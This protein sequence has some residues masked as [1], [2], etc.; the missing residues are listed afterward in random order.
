MQSNGFDRK[1]ILGNLKKNI[2]SNPK[3]GTLC[4]QKRKSTMTNKIKKFLYILEH[5]IPDG[6]DE[7]PTFSFNHRNIQFLAAK[8][9]Q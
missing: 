2:F 8:A 9:A 4:S 1:M 6:Y 5:Q 3:A 7:I